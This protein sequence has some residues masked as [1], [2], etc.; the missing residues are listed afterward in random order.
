MLTLH[1]R[2]YCPSPK[3]PS[4]AASHCIED[5]E[6][7]GRGPGWRASD[8]LQ[9]R[10][11]RGEGGTER[12][13]SSCNA[14]HSFSASSGANRPAATE[15]STSIRSR[16][17]R[18]ATQRAAAVRPRFGAGP[19]PQ[20]AHAAQGQLGPG[21]AALARWGL[22]SVTQKCRMMVGRWASFALPSEDPMPVSRTDTLLQHT[23]QVLEARGSGGGPAR[24][25]HGRHVLCARPCRTR[26]AALQRWSGPR[27]LTLAAF[28][29]SCSQWWPGHAFQAAQRRG[30]A[31]DGQ[32]CRGPK[33]HSNDSMYLT[34][35]PQ[36]HPPKAAEAF[37]PRFQSIAAGPGLGGCGEGR[38]LFCKSPGSV[39]RRVRILYPR[40]LPT[41]L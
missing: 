19:R 26:T 5:V 22:T 41:V 24:S 39:P 20:R 27:R 14:K 18:R 1:T 6:S 32:L 13:S 21:G 35:K 2:A 23:Q 33:P 37:H 28:S 16:R 12:T 3:P 10:A 38:H 4:L 34:P 17:L 8:P 9:S 25:R 36:R 7:G 29:R 11:I 40:Q 30:H 15:T 31:L